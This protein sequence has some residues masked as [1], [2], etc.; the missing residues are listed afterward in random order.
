MDFFRAQDTILWYKNASE[1]RLDKT[2]F[3]NLRLVRINF[4]QNIDETHSKKKK[5]T[6]NP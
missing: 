3:V 5:T 1:G 2:A 4:K 6:K